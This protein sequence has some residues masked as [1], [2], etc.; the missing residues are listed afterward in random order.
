MD[1]FNFIIFLPESK[2]DDALENIR[3]K[4]KGEWT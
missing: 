4:K 2:L 3:P 1:I